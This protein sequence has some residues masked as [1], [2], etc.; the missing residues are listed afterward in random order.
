MEKNQGTL[1]KSHT[2]EGFQ[3]K[4]KLEHKIDTT[5]YN[6]EVSNEIIAETPFD[7]ERCS[8]RITQTPALRMVNI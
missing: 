8:L 6:I 5:K 1:E 3:K 4:N 7:Y 2:E